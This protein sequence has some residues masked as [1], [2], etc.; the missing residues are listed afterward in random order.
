M[1]LGELIVILFMVS[2]ICITIDTVVQKQVDRTKL[3]ISGLEATVEAYKNNL[4]E[5][6]HDAR[7]D[8]TESDNN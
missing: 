5:C 2:I 6:L 7:V 4:Q 8:T 3:T 1:K